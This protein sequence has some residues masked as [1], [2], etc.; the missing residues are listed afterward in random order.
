MVAAV[1]RGGE[2]REPPLYP[3]DR[4]GATLLGPALL[5]MEE[6]DLGEPLD[7]YLHRVERG[8]HPLDHVRPGRRVAGQQ[9][10]APLG[11]VED[12]RSRFEQGKVAV[13]DRRNL[14][15]W[16]DGAIGG[17]AYRALTVADQGDAIGQ[18]GLLERPAH[19]QVADQP[20]RERG[21][22]TE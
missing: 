2:L 13:L 1:E 14:A 7:G 4:G 5:G 16:L 21:H 15:E 8:E 3:L 18:A 19:P 10:V 12:D 11:D 22:G 20:P 17:R 6:V 9:S